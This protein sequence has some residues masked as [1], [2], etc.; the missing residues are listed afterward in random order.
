MADWHQKTVKDVFSDLK[1][2]VKGLPSKEAAV[3]LEKCGYNRIAA[4][5]KF[6]PLKIFLNQFRSFL[7][8]ILIFAAVISAVF[9]DITDAVLILIIV[10][11]NSIL[12]FVQEFRAEKSMEALKKLTVP[13]AKV[14]RDGKIKEISSEQLVPGDIV[15]IESGDSIPADGRLIELVNLQVDESSLT[16]ESAAV[17][18]NQCV[19]KEAVVADRKNMVFMGTIATTGR[20]RYAVTETGMG[21]EIGKIA[22]FLDKIETETPLQKRLGHFGRWLGLAVI[23]IAAATFVLG[24]VRGEQLYTM[25]LTSVTIAVS[26]VPEGLPAIVTVTLAL[27]TRVM[28]RKNAI[29]R[30]LSAVESLGSVTVICSDKTGTLT[31]N[32]M[33]VKKIFAGN[34]IIDVSGSGFDVNG[35]FLIGKKSAE[36]K[37]CLEE[38][39]K[40]GILCNDSHLV[41]NDNGGYKIVGDP[42][43]GALL[44][45]GAK[46]GFWKDKLAEKYARINEIPFTSERKM[47]TTIHQADNKKFAYFKGAPEK[48]LSICKIPDKEKGKINK[49]VENMGKDG[50]RVLAFAKKRIKGKADIGALEKNLIFAGLAGMID[51]PR[52]EV[53]DAIKTCRQAGI[54]VVMITGDHRVT[55]EAVGKE[56]GLLIKGKERILTG[57]ELDKMDYSELKRVVKQVNIY[58]R[59]SPENKLSIVSALKN[60]GEIV[61]VTGDGVNDAPALKK[62]DV[63]IA[64]G[65]KGTDVAKDASDIVLADDN[66]STIVSAVEEGRG[67]YENIRKFVR[68]ILSVNFSEIFFITLSVLFHLPLPLLPVQILWI[69]LL[70]DGVPA[71]TLTVDQKEKDIMKRKPRDPKATITSN[72]KIFILTAGMV[73]L[74]ADFAAFAIGLSHS[75]EKA[76]TMA[77][78]ATVL[79]ELAFVFNCRSESRSVF[80]KNPLTNKYLCVSAV[81]TI[82]LQLSIIYMPQLSAM[83]QTVPLE[84]ADWLIIIPLSLSGLLVLPELF[85]GK[86]LYRSNL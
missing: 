32:E 7:V 16:G 23:I 42:T 25:A 5:K 15:L 9:A 49:T 20:A 77:L 4:R 84:L 12:G 21:T 2:G 57:E 48:I 71:L 51:P 11:I 19:L 41:K 40:I 68:Y 30:K 67:V 17:Q 64:M 13:V 39:L 78:T 70:T 86:S 59:I 37:G 65:I 50:L 1:T 54:R 79:F 34:K 26:A 44:V 63:G 14:L 33:T 46:A 28:A 56:I 35:D 74:A 18:K 82:L 29:I 81:L 55:A 22:G 75:I 24:L 83:F 27:G 6:G 36:V 58:A 66:F 80:R 47:M 31:T 85:M 69:N 61:A 72:S 10:I 60:N 62:A 52:K 43:E 73:L 38:L 45:A 76:R 53:K 3:R 8:L